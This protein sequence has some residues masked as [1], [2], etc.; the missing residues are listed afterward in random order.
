MGNTCGLDLISSNCY[1]G[2]WGIVYFLVSKVSGY[3]SSTLFR[4]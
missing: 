3:S 4:I 1:M 2:I